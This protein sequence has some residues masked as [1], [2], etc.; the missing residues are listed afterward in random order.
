MYL[1]KLLYGNYLILKII[2]YTLNVLDKM[3]P[4]MAK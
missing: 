4:H 3:S 2:V 1:D